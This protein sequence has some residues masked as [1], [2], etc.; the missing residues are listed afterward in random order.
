MV[1][2]KTDLLSGRKI[3]FHLEPPIPNICRLHNEMRRIIRFTD[4]K[5]FPRCNW[6]K[7]EG[8]EKIRTSRLF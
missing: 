1:R 3:N 4:A 5:N 6:K 2:N 8:N 7:K